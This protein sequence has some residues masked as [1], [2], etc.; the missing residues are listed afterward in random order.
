MVLLTAVASAFVTGDRHDATGT[1]ATALVGPGV[2]AGDAE[3]D[4][5]GEG[6]WLAGG[7]PEMAEAAAS[8]FDPADA[9]AE[10]SLDGRGEL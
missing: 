1:I 9:A 10:V 6:S 7:V 8:G 4:V 5:D 2:A 3:G